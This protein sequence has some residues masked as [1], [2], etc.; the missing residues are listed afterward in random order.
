VQTKE[1]VSVGLSVT[2]RFKL[3]SSRLPSMYNKLPQ[4]FEQEI[5]PPV[6]ASAFREAAPNY[7]VRELFATRRDEMARL[8]AGEIARKLAADGVIVK[9]VMVREILLPAEYAKGME[10][11]LLKEQE[12]ERLTVELE[13]KQE[14]VK[15]AE[16]E[17]EAEKAREIKQAEAAAQVTVLQA[18]AQADA[19]QQTL[20][21]KEKQIQ[22]SRLEAEACK[23]A[24]VKNAEAMAEA[25]VIDSKAELER[26]K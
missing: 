14:M 13:V 2:A 8:V 1:A 11:L 6:I 25:K 15:E 9:E 3:D 17:T 12:N 4:P 20:S 21:L 7:S 23:E 18:K 5:L 19:M 22:Q 24:T 26:R 16:V 10:G